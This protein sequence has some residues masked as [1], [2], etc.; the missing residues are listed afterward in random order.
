MY[1]YPSLGAGSVQ[2]WTVRQCCAFYSKADLIFPSV[3]PICVRKTCLFQAA[4]DANI[5]IANMAI[6]VSTRREPTT[7]L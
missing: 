7:Q 6:T 1:Q 2:R 4:K 5:V 3:A